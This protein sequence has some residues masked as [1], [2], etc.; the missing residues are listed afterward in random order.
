MTF[1]INIGKYGGFY[2]RRDFTTRLCLGWIAFT[3]F[4]FDIDNHLQH[5]MDTTIMLMGI[6][7]DL[8]R[9]VKDMQLCAAQRQ[10]VRRD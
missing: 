6:V 5:Q 8:S 10:G 4:P 1:A 2:W 7:D 3:F 9:Q